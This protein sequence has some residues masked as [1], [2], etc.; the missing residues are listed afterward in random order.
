MLR[1]R[2]FI[3]WKYTTIF[4]FA[5]LEIRFYAQFFLFTY[6][7]RNYLFIFTIFAIMIAPQ[8]GGKCY[9]TNR[10]N[11][12][13][14]NQNHRCCVVLHAHHTSVPRFYGNY[15]RVVWLAGKNSVPACNIGYKC[16]CNNI[17]CCAD[18]PF[19]PYLLLCN[20]PSGYYA[21]YYIVVCRP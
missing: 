20:M 18:T 9:I 15:T 6:Q 14:K 13:A 8:K 2:K 10:I 19:W 5:K 12:V 7:I 17:S 1:F 11:Y 21:G 3:R 16:W 4:S